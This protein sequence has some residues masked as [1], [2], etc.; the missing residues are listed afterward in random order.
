MESLR[1]NEFVAENKHT[2]FSP[3]NGTNINFISEPG[4]ELSIPAFLKPKF[5]EYCRTILGF[6]DQWKHCQFHMRSRAAQLAIDGTIKDFKQFVE[7]VTE[8]DH[9]DP[10]AV[11]PRVTIHNRGTVPFHFYDSFEFMNIWVSNSDFLTGTALTNLVDNKTINLDG[12]WEYIY[13]EETGK[14]PQMIR[15]KLDPLARYTTIDSTWPAIISN[16]GKNHGR[17]DVKNYIR[18]L[19]VGEKSPFLLTQTHARISILE[20]AHLVVGEVGSTEDCLYDQTI[21]SLRSC[22]IQGNNTQN[23]HIKIEIKD[24]VDNPHTIDYVNFYVLPA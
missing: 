4:E 11:L 18:P 5:V 6:A 16:N 12:E 3:N 23:H 10:L 17:E 13:D 8:F 24:N 1:R 2:Y 9:N 22:L 20:G 21:F 19:E 15:C 14:I 7:Q